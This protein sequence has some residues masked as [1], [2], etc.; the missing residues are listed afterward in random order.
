MPAEHGP[1]AITGARCG[2]GRNLAEHYLSLGW[3]V[4]GCSR[5]DSDLRHDEYRHSLVDVTDEGAVRRWLAGIRRRHGSLAALVNNAGVAAMNHALL[6]PGS[7]VAHV[8]Q[9]NISGTFLVSREAAKLMRASG[10]RIVNLSS[11]AVPL[12]LEGE[13]I[14]SAAKAAV[15]QL[16]RVL[17]REFADFAITVNAVGPTPI[18]TDLLRGVPEEALQQLLQKQPIHRF[19]TMEDVHNVVDFFLSPRSGFVTGQI[20]YLGGVG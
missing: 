7:T 17:A 5:S 18:R 2:I 19:G 9:T 12:R 11:V 3:A 20:I 10:G 14:Y 4:E 15:E 1:I 6:T 13:A 16:T 8:L